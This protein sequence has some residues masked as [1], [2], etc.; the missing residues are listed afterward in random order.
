MDQGDYLTLEEI[1]QATTHEVELPEMTKKL[2][3][4]AA[5]AFRAIGTSDYLTLIPLPPPGAE[6]WPVENFWKHELDWIRTLPEDEQV[7][8]R[9][10]RAE[11]VY[12]T[13][14]MASLRPLLSV[15]TARRLGNDAQVAFAAILVESGIMPRPE[16]PPAAA[17]ADA[18]TV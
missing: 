14:A 17:P 2:G 3:K 15:E 13:V 5:L 9:E 10:A 7:K 16:T 4:R 12:R 1:E 18:A 6:A 11:V 8:A